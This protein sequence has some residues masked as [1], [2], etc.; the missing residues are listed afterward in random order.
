M[1]HPT[2]QTYLLND[3]YKTASNLNARIQ[4]HARFSQNTYHWPRWVFDHIT[5]AP[6][7]HILEITKDFGLFEAR[8]KDYPG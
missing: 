5:A 8:R 3:Q 7:S 1:S 4:L 2:D 6:A